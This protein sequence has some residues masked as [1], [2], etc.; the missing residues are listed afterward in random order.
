MARD[1]EGV[2]VVLV[3]QSPVWSVGMA[4]RQRV[5]VV[6]PDRELVEL[7]R[8]AFG[9]KYHVTGGP[10]SMTTI[11][12]QRPDLLVVGPSTPD[13][14][15]LGSWEIVALAR[16]HRHLGTV[17]IIVLSCDLDAIVAS[18]TQLGAYRDVHVIGMPFELEVLDGVISSVNRAARAAEAAATD[19]LLAVGRLAR[20]NDNVRPT[21]SAPEYRRARRTQREHSSPR[22]RSDAG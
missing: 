7:L 6:H 17:P 18:G 1:G 20:R 9:A 3:N 13:G 2:D 5:S 21:L 15:S 19:K 8:D 12:G 14:E 16:A 4:L 11:A 10:A 22:R